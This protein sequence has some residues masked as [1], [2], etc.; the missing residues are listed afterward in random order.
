MVE[1]SSAGQLMNDS[2]NVVELVKQEYANITSSVQLKHDM[3]KSLSEYVRIKY[4]S[5][6][7]GGR[8]LVETDTCSGLRVNTQVAFEIKIELIRCPPNPADWQQTIRIRTVGLQ[9]E[10][11]IDLQMLCDCDCE[12]QAINNAPQCN[13]FGS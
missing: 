13:G 11:I 12:R 7:V 4:Y 8:Q 10:L 5:K 3:R 9:D 6:C 2:S 1:G